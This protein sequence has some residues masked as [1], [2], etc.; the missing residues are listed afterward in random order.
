MS[1]PR[2]LIDPKARAQ[3]LARA[4]RAPVLFLQ[5]AVADDL[6]DRLS[7]V[8]RTFTDTA[9]IS[10]WATLWP[11]R[12]TGAQVIAPAETLPLAENSCDLVLHAMCLHWAA[13]PVGQ[14]IQARRALRPDGLLIAA[15]F[16]GQTLHELRT[17]LAEAESRITGGLSP[18]VLPMA[19]LRDLG[20]LLQRAG[21]ALPVSDTFSLTVNYADPLQLMR[22]LRMMGEGNA[23][24][25]RLR[26]PTRRAIMAEAG[27]IYADQFGDS[28]GRI[29]ATFE[30]CVLTGWAPASSQ[31]K[32]LRPGTAAARLADVLNTDETK[33]PD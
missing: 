12:I 5:E 9:V 15:L 11:D 7:L 14:L 19:D 3:N 13:D 18:R 17:A 1:D 23:L 16:G 26:H 22:E 25:D 10:P 31:P 28:D 6:Q 33:L 24:S 21:L 30:I 20:G 2:S 29:P 27:R 32:P 4:A 8:N